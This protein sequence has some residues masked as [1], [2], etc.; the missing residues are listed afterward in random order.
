MPGIRG[1]PPG[2][3]F[4]SNDSM[5]RC[6]LT[7]TACCSATVPCSSKMEACCRAM[8]A[9]RTLREP[10]VG[11][12]SVSIPL[13]CRNYRPACYSF[14]IGF[15]PIPLTNAEQLPCLGS[16]R[17]FYGEFCHQWP[18][19][20][21]GQFACLSHPGGETGAALLRVQETEDPPNVS[22]EGMPLGS[23]RNLAN[24]TLRL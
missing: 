13:V 20:P 17:G 12:I 1:G 8:N 11:S 19:L 5:R 23:F 15:R 9:S 3:A 4:P 7:I 10:I 16:G 14:S 21:L 18:P 24:Q 22:W 2:F 6:N